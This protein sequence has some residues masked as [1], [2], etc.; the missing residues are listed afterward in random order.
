M[1]ARRRAWTLAFAEMV[2]ALDELPDDCRK[3]GS[4]RRR[5]DARAAR[6]RRRSPSPTSGRARPTTRRAPSRTA[7]AQRSSADERPHEARV[8]AGA[9]QRHAEDDPGS[10]GGRGVPDQ[11]LARHRGGARARGRSSGGRDGR[12]RSLSILADLPGPKVR[13]ASSIPTRSRSVPGSGSSSARRPRRRGRRRHDVPGLARDLREAMTASCSPTA[14]GAGRPLD[15]RRRRG[16]RVRPRRRRA[17]P[18]GGERARR[19]ARPPA[20][21]RSR[22]RDAP[23]RPRPRRRPG[24]AVVRARGGRR[25][26]APRGDGGRSVPIVAKIETRPAVD[27][28]ERIL[29][30]RTR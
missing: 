14:R 16:D 4:S 8:H 5:S 2:D 20:G 21:D 7:S 12:R 22:P 30:A 28:F 25:R 13:L 15:R 24:R 19:A 1:G 18:S 27:D 17:E 3:D 11:L 6:C 26:A 23:A 10:S 9:R 29:E